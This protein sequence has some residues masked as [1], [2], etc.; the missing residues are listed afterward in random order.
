WMGAEARAVLH[1]ADNLRVIVGGEWQD[2][3]HVAQRGG[4][5]LDSP[6]PQAY[7]ASENSFQFGARYADLD[8]KLPDRRLHVSAG[9]RLGHYSTFGN[10]LNPRLGLIVKPSDA[11][12]IKLMGGKAFRAPSIYELYYNDGGLSQIPAGVLQPEE[13]WSGEIE[14]THHLSPL[15]TVVGSAWAS[16]ISDIIQ[17]AELDTGVSRYRNLAET[18][19]A[20]GAEAELR[21]EWRQ[22]WMASATWSFSHWPDTA[23]SPEHMASLKLAAPLVQRALTAM[24][25]L[26]IESP[27]KDRTLSRETS[28]AA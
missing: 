13:I 17:L 6:S 10:A 5:N 24:T 9:A 12:V 7:L 27:R 19:R 11:D 16:Q 28:W 8:L 26:S 4:S 22:G 2:H 18:V 14:L 21:R 15:W 3:F 23:N 1:P 20:V 25:R